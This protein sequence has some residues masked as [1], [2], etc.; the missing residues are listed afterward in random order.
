MGDFVKS[1]RLIPGEDDDLIERVKH[2]RHGEL[3]MYVRRGL[4]RVFNE[5]PPWESVFSYKPEGTGV[6]YTVIDAHTEQTPKARDIDDIL[7]DPF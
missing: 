1:F 4:R 2:M 5:A 7:K 6:R 3:S